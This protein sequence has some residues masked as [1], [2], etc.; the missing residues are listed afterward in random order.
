LPHPS[1]TADS[2][3]GSDLQHGMAA[4]RESDCRR[5]TA[6]AGRPRPIEAQ[7]L[8]VPPMTDVNPTMPVEP[9]RESG[10]TRWANTKLTPPR[11]PAPLKFWRSLEELREGSAGPRRRVEQTLTPADRVSREQFLRLMG[12]SLALAGLTACAGEP[13]GPQQIAPY[14]QRP[15]GVSP[16]VSLYFAT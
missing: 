9:D 5:S 2:P 10:G 8:G 1:R 13:K 6:D 3:P 12:A 15:A 11:E 14:V 16:A 7:L 4:A